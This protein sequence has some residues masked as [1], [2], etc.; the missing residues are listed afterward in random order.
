ME[1]GSKI[2][3]LRL[4]AGMTQD[5]LAEELGVSFQTISKWENGVCAPDI[6]MLPK[7]SVYFGVTIDELF[8]LTTEQKLHR[9]ENMLDMENE[10]PHST[11]VETI[12]Y[13]QDLLEKDYDKGRIYNFLAH[14]YYHRV[15]SDCDKAD[16]YVRKS[17]KLC[18]EQKNC[19]WILQKTEGAAICDWNAR[20][21]HR[22]ISFYKELIKENPTVVRNYLDLMDNLLADNRTKEAAEYLEQYKKLENHAKMQVPI[23]EGR[24]ALAEHNVELAEQK[25]KELEMNF[26]K[27]G[28]A[29]FELAG[30]YAE[31]CD[32]EKAL[33]FYEISF[34]LDK[35]NG[36]KPLYT[37][38]L[39]GMAVIYEIQEKYE[40]ALKCY[41]R[42][43][44]VLD[45]EF[46]FAEGAPVDE[47]NTEKQRVMEL[48]RSNNKV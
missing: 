2:K 10:L 42:V 6:M 16:K 23:Y 48:M 30:H 40:E 38:A 27:D 11:F 8:D 14:V 24:I 26:A 21:H 37:D 31:Q 12:D 18:P 45:E 47:V 7:L 46:G 39:W 25:F 9:I 33:H 36:K 13:L 15:A 35:E 19:G 17:L 5:M 32:Y 41:D 29:M 34:A 3:A 4:R 28:G 22:I 43:L 1:L 44:K 20:N